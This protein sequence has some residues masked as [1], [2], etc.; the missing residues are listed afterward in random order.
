MDLFEGADPPIRWLAVAGS[1]IGDIDY[2]GAD[3]VRQVKEELARTGITFAICDL[4][5]KVRGQL[6]AYGLTG[7]IGADRVFATVRELAAAYRATPATNPAGV[8]SA[9]G[10]SPAEG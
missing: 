10:T 5:P 3:T 9:A 4:S 6:D 1:S 8:A 7:T 2:S